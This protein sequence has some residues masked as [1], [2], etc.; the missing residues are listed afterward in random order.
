MSNEFTKGP[1]NLLSLSHYNE[2]NCN[3]EHPNESH[4]SWEGRIIIEMLID[5]GSIHEVY[6]ELESRIENFQKPV[7]P[8][9]E[10]IP[11]DKDELFYYLPK[12]FMKEKKVQWDKD[13]EDKNIKNIILNKRKPLKNENNQIDINENN[14]EFRISFWETPMGMLIGLFLFL[15]I[16]GIFVS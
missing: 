6:S 11:M 5:S 4:D 8:E 13:L 3:I 9:F 2:K 10:N 14:N 15:I 12:K 7:K 1:Y 16:L